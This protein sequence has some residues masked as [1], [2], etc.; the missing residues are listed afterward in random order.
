MQE[1]LHFPEQEI[2]RAVGIYPLCDIPGGVYRRPG[3]GICNTAQAGGLLLQGFRR[4][5]R[6]ALLHGFLG[7]DKLALV[8][9][10]NS[11]L[12]PEHSCVLKLAVMLYSKRVPE[13]RFIKTLAAVAKQEQQEFKTRSVRQF[14]IFINDAGRHC[15]YAAPCPGVQ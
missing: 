13:F 3:A 4:D 1:R 2:H 7:R 9:A 8:H 12:E 15:E 6:Q 10:D 14:Y 11:A 5:L